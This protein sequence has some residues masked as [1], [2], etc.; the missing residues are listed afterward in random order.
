MAAQITNRSLMKSATCGLRF[1]AAVVVCVSPFVHAQESGPLELSGTVALSG[2]QGGFNHMTVDA[3]GHR[4]FAAAPTNTSVEVVDI[5][6][7]QPVQSMK[8][9]KPA[10]TLYAPEFNQLYVSREQSVFIYDGRT[11][12]L[13]K[14][15]DLQ[16]NVDELRYDPGAKELY[17]GCMSPEKTGFAVISIPEGSF[18]GKIALPAKPQGFSVEQKGDRIFANSPALNEVAVVDRK[19]RTLVGTWPMGDVHGNYPMAL[20]EARHRLF[21]GARQPAELVILD[22]DSGKV[23]AKIGIH[24][25]TDDLFYD[26]K[27]QR[28]YVSCGEGFVDVIRQRD[29]NHYQTV[30]SIST[31]TGARTSTYSPEL[32]SFVLGVPRRGDLPAEIRVYKAD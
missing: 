2:V 9:V 21:I 28:I 10:A 32:K 14:K 16:S 25:D 11:L 30:G 23:V 27:D 8:G 12:E 24:R 5:K 18:V 17:A 1:L 26:S 29:A 31:V 4:V 19:K 6:S 13:L 3:L 20:D 15:I 22:T 7:G